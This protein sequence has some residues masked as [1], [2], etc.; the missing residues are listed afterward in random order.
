MATLINNLPALE[1]P[2]IVS[3]DAEVGAG[4]AP[5]GV[6]SIDSEDLSVV[7]GAG[8]RTLLCN[9]GATPAGHDVGATATYASPPAEANVPTADEKAALDGANSPSASNV[10]ATVADLTGDGSLLPT[11]D[12]KAALDGAASPSVSNVF[13][14]MAD[15]PTT[16]GL[17]AVTAVDAN[18]GATMFSQ[19][20]GAP[21]G[22]LTTFLYF[23]TTASTGGLYAWDGTAYQKVGLATT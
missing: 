13:A 8:S 1:D 14:T 10:F 22:T 2:V 12:E 19:A 17:A 3:L 20:A 9:R 16:P 11:A 4:D 21:G 18:P 6:L 23:D 15:V 7:A 5:G